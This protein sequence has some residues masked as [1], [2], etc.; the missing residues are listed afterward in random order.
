MCGVVGVSLDSPSEKQIQIIRNVL[1]E[2]EIRGKHA[3]GIAWY[4]G[5]LN[6]IRKPVPISKLLE[7]VNIFDMIH[8]DKLRMVA[9]IRYSTSDLMYNQPIGDKSLY[10]CHNGVVTQTEPEEWGELFGYS[11]EGRND[12]ELIFKHMTS[13][14]SQH[15]SEKFPNISY[16][17][18]YIDNN[19]TVSYA[20][21]G[22]RPLWKCVSDNGFIVS[23][24][25]DILK[26]AGSDL[27]MVS[28]VDVD[29]DEQNR[30]SINPRS[31]Y[32]F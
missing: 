28:K 7:E 21:N 24:T 11:C 1:L 22:L 13:G 29:Q 2:T 27:S 16:A 31:L 8:D 17:L 25:Y 20:R 32:G 15:L 10:I 23:S 14:S 18:T 26:R 30:S 6:L 5:E 12:S 19:G 4:N 3:S 9:H